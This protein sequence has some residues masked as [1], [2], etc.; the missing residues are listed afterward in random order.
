MYQEINKETDLN[1]KNN[2]LTKHTKDIESKVGRGSVQQR[3]SSDNT[4][5]PLEEA[6]FQTTAAAAG[7]TE[8][9]AIPKS[10]DPKDGMNVTRQQVFLYLH[11]VTVKIL[12]FARFLFSH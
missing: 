5:W 4:Y 9:S 7:S 2:L 3:Y 11:Q 6:V 12:F 10:K 8:T 1:K